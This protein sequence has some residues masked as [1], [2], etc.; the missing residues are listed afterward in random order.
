M[1]ELYLRKPNTECIVCKKQIYRRPVQINNNLGKVYCG[2]KCYGLSC[3][4]ETPCL[5][6]GE[7]ILSTHN[8]KTCSRSCSNKY[9][10]GISYKLGRSKDRATK[11][12]N[13]KLELFR[14][15]GKKCERC[16]YSVKEVLQVHHIDRNR[17]NNNKENLEIICPNCH[18]TEHYLNK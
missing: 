5:V 13:I 2:Q 17:Q 9:R 4:K 12:R 10:T 18:Y 1:P 16:G 15:R 11:S 14:V 8:K 6:C 3:R 7:L